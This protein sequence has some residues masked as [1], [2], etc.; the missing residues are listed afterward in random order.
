MRPFRLASACILPATAAFLLAACATSDFDPGRITRPAE[1][2]PARFLVHG[3][4]AGDA[5]SET[6]LEKGCRSPMVDPDSGIR[7]RLFRSSGTEGDY[8]AP[9]GAYGLRSRELLRLD[10]RSGEVL[11]VVPR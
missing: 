8:E 10:C 11:G 2:T 1:G 3:D 6:S 9:S 7:L 4:G 5:P